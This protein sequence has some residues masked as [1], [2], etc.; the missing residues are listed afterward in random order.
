MSTCY[1][2]VND[3]NQVF[4]Y[5]SVMDGHF[6]R[7]ALNLNTSVF[8]EVDGYNLQDYLLR[9]YPEVTRVEM[10]FSVSI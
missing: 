8:E 5:I 2:V 10:N 7:H 4:Y 1:R 6:K 3:K 9:N